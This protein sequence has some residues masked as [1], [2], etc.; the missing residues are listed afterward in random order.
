MDINV[1]KRNIGLNEHGGS[2]TFRVWAPQAKRVAIE[3]EK[4][5]ER[6]YLEAEGRGYWG[7]ETTAIVE[8]D[9]YRIVLDD[10]R[11]LPDPAALAQPEGVHGPSM[12]VRLGGYD[13]EDT[14]W[15][16]PDLK[17][18]II[19][20]LH[21][22]TFSDAGDFEG[23][24]SKLDYLAEL[25]IT[26]I[27]LM[28]VAAFPGKRNWGYDGVFPFAVQ[29]NYGGADGLRRL[30]E[31]CHE[32]GLAV[33]LD[34]VYNHLGPEGNCLS[35]F[36]PY[37]T[38]KYRTPW[39]NAIN[40]DDRDCYGVRDYF[41][42][43]VLMW[44]RDF[45]IDALRLDAVHAIKDFSAVHILQAIR[46][47]TDLLMEQTGR[48]HYL[49]AECDLNDPRYIEDTRRNGLG[50]DAQWTDEFHHALRVTAGEER[51]GYYADFS[52]I[53]HLAK[54]YRDAYVYTG[55]FSE[56]RGQYFGRPL[57]DHEGQQFVVF[58]Q[59]HDQVGNRMMGER[60]GTLVSFE[61]QKLL[62]AAVLFSPYLPMLFMGEEW[63]ET[64]PFQ[65]FI[66][67]ED[68]ELVELVRKGRKE[69]FAAMHAAGEA[70]DPKAE[71]TFLQCKLNWSLPVTG[72]HER[73][74][75]Y[76]RHLIALRKQNQVLRA[77][78]RTALRCFTFDAQHC[79]MLERRMTGSNELVLC[80][81]NFSGQPQQL[82]LPDHVISPT[83]I[84]D[85]ADPEWLGPGSVS[86]QLQPESFIAYSAFY[87]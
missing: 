46:Q 66:D 59:N 52:G 31:C 27:E 18:Y 84:V 67:H 43:N 7:T 9:R 79:L 41:I 45:H 25:G 39:G 53:A 80:L 14:G 76:Y 21:T 15:K 29:W 82:A 34:V 33:I 35:E 63:G 86:G 70:P 60:T 77:G 81:M 8:G 69:E 75:A 16:N 87:A 57:A 3:L 19:Y 73:M 48:R 56:E 42:E 32:K 72:R 50:M 5:G 1:L 37:F 64:N 58:S 55:Q 65:Y 36:G 71:Q 22:G 51:R 40:F 28:P 2:W 78:E 85:S 49:I 30:V 17:D 47:H 54:S 20:E 11:R 23:I 83:K 12:A 68:A 44:F 6:I 38:E 62:A 61:M 74:L 13:W 4:S 26:A 24:A 10:D